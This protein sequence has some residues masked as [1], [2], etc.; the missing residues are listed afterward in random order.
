[1]AV[2]LCARVADSLAKRF[3]TLL[4]ASTS[5]ICMRSED[6]STAIPVGEDHGSANEPPDP[7]CLPLVPLMGSPSK[8]EHEPEASHP[9]PTPASAAFSLSRRVFPPSHPIYA[10][11]VGDGMQLR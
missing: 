2:A 11:G 1:M 3:T 6:M 5:C 4:S 8:A 7:S 9:G 10:P